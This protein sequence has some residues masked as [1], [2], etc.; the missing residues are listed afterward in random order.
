MARVLSSVVAVAIA[1]LAV[2][3]AV[4]YLDS[5]GGDVELDTALARRGL[6]ALAADALVTESLAD[7]RTCPLGQMTGLATALEREGVLVSEA[8]RRG[9]TEHYV[10]EDPPLPV[11]AVCLSFAEGAVPDDE[12]GASSF[13]MAVARA[14]DDLA[15][16]VQLLAGGGAQVELSPGREHD[17][18]TLHHYCATY[19]DDPGAD[20][21]SADWLDAELLVSVYVG[22]QLDDPAALEGVVEAML[23]DIVDALAMAAPDDE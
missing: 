15:A 9:A 14:P 19:P 8:A 22:G 23:D 5:G 11:T 17:V 21:C 6:E 4:R 10:H 7:L 2:V 18:G 13:G 16:Y 20:Y 3:L 12:I 1:V